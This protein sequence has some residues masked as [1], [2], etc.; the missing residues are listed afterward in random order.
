MNLDEIRTKARDGTLDGSIRL[1]EVPRGAF[2]LDGAHALAMGDIRK[3]GTMYVVVY[4]DVRPLSNKELS[5]WMLR[6]IRAAADALKLRIEGTLMG[7][8]RRLPSKATA[9]SETAEMVAWTTSDPTEHL[10]D[11]TLMEEHTAFT[12]PA[13]LCAA[14]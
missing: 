3:P 7:S 2:R 11:V 10:M 4:A 9:A 1:P 6:A 13:G 14:T 12:V 5:R 8:L